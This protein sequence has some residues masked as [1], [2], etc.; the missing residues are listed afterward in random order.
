MF[1]SN[2]HEDTREYTEVTSYKKQMASHL[3]V[4]EV[5][6]FIRGFHEYQHFWTPAIGEV[7]VLKREPTNPF[8][9]YTAAVRK[10]ETVVSAF[11]SRDTNVGF[12]EV[13]GARVN[14]GGG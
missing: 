12:A 6:S 2:V 7:N 1:S 8:D 14:R 9:S 10:D 11:L 3:S 4:Y 5:R 13:A